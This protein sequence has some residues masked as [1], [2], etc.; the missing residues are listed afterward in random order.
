MARRL[1]AVLAADVAGHPR[2]MEADERV[3]L[4][5]LEACESRVVE[6]IEE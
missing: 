4:R 6:P 2:L 5:R 1:S 3:T